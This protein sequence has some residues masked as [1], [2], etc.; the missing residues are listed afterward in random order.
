MGGGVSKPRITRSQ[1]LAAT[2]DNREFTNR[3]F[4]AMI[5][6]LTPEDFLSLAHSQKCSQFVFMMADSIGNLFEAIRV[7]PRRDKDSGIIYFQRISALA[8]PPVPARTAETRELCLTI[9]YFYIRIFQI[10]GALAMTVIDS[11]G[12]G[13]VLGV[14][15][16]RV[17]Q[18]PGGIAAPGRRVL[19]GGGLDDD[20]ETVLQRGGVG[21]GEAM[22]RTAELLPIAVMFGAGFA[23]PLPT[24]QVK[25]AYKFIDIPNAT[26]IPRRVDTK[27]KPLNLKIELADGIVFDANLSLTLQRSKAGVKYNTKLEN[28][29][30]RK[31]PGEQKPALEAYNK[32][33]T[34]Y[35]SQTLIHFDDDTWVLEDNTTPFSTKLVNDF[36]QIETIIREI[37]SNPTVA[38]KDL[39]AV[40]A[41]QKR[42]LAQREGQVG[43]AFA[44]ADGRTDAFITKPLRYEYIVKVL[45][46]L[47]GAKSVNFCVA[48]ALQLLDAN[49]LAQPRAT[50]GL[51][52]VCMA[53]FEP[54]P[55]SVP[56]AGVAIT[57]VPGIQA[58]DQLFYTKPAVTA[59]EQHQVLVGDPAEYAEFLAGM[60]GLFGGGTAQTRELRSADEIRAKQPCDKVVKEYLRI[61][62]PKVVAQVTGIVNTMFARE[63]AHTRRV[64][65]FFRTKLFV[66]KKVGGGGTTVELHPALLRGGIAEVNKLSAEAR[67]ILIEYYKG[68]EDL[69]QSGAQIV[70]RSGQKEA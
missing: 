43:V 10:F 23:Y 50:T 47:V 68:C 65:Q 29:Q 17:P 12:A 28:I 21:E 11:Q 26:Y 53:R 24:G 64:I 46:G 56:Q 31:V 33:L 45:K 4:Q 30:L 35:A 66:F 36:E 70:L 6:Q 57:S 19:L 69:Y 38:Y 39:A 5:G 42:A 15:Q 13:D 25:T 41:A 8:K 61:T 60:A 32:K 58:L 63:L 7:R 2:A 40:P 37:L 1:L 51:S 52:G 27:Q 67:R 3:L 49:A 22:S 44:G 9:A 20:E 59:Q 16:Y 48:R 34:N 55:T 18:G 62:D 14:L 54:L